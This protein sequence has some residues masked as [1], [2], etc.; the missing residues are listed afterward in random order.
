M[1][2]P[3]AEVVDRFTILCIKLEKGLDCIKELDSYRT[4]IERVDKALV[5][6]LRTINKQMWEA[7][8]VITELIENNEYTKV[9][10]KY[11]ALRR[12]TIE[13]NVAKNQIAGRHGEYQN[14]KKY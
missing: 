2:M 1:K 12:L 7:E 14:I 5:N 10:R 9:G 11:K 3:L 4:S 13:R 8:E 6:K